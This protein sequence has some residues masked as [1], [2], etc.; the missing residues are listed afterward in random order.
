MSEIPELGPE[1]LAESRDQILQD[2]FAEARARLDSAKQA[3]SKSTV[4]A[5]LFALN[6]RGMVLGAL[7]KQGSFVVP[8]AP[9]QG[10]P[11]EVLMEDAL[12]RFGGE[13]EKLA[14]LEDRLET[15][16]GHNRIDTAYY[17][18]TCQEIIGE[19][20]NGLR[21]VAFYDPADAASLVLGD[22]PL[23]VRRRLIL[24]DLA[25][26]LDSV[27][28]QTKEAAEA[29]CPCG[30]SWVNCQGCY[31]G[32]GLKNVFKEADD[33]DGPSEKVLEKFKPNFTP[34]ELEDMNV[35]V[36]IHHGVS[37]GKR[38][39]SMHLWTT[40]DPK[41]ELKESFLDWFKQFVG[42]RKHQ[43]DAR[44]MR[45]WIGVHSLHGS[46][47]KKKPSPARAVAL[48]NWSID[49]VSLVPEDMK[50]TVSGMLLAARKALD[51]KLEK[52]ASAFLGKLKAICNGL[53][54]QGFGISVA[55]HP[56][57]GNVWVDLHDSAE[58]PKWFNAKINKL[59]GKKVEWTNEAAPK[60]QADGWSQVYASGDCRR[61]SKKAS[62]L[63]K[64]F[65]RRHQDPID[66]AFELAKPYKHYT[67][68]GSCGC[69]LAQC[70][71][72][73]KDH[74]NVHVFE[75]TI[76]RPC[77]DCA[78]PKKADLLPNVE[79]LQPQQA[80]VQQ[81][82]LDPATRMLLYHG[83][84]TG[85]SRSA[86]AAAE[87]AGK[88]YTAVTP[89]ALRPN[90]QKERE[91]WTDLKTPEKTYSYTAL[92]QGKVPDTDTLILDEA[93]R[94]RSPTA[95]QTQKAM[96]LASRAHHVYLLSGTPIVNHPH[97]LAPMLSI[98]TNNQMTPEQFD[99]QFLGEEKV[100]PGFFGWM[101]GIKP[102][103]EPSVKNEQTLRNLLEG[104][105]SYYA[106]AKP[107]VDRQDEKYEVSMGPEQ[108][109]LYHSFWNQLPFFMRWKLQRQFPLSHEEMTHLSS[110]LSG[111][112]QVGLST[113]PF[114]RGAKGP[115]AAFQAFKQSPKLHKAFGLMTDAL[116]HPDMKGVVYSNFIEA[117][118]IPYA[119]ALEKAGV[120]YGMFH[121]ALN[122]V[123][124]K[125]VVDAYN[126]GK[127]KVL[128]LGP[129]ASEG[130]SLKGT[131]LLQVLDPHW[132][133]ARTDQAIGRGI[134]FDSH[135]D[136]PIEERNIRVQRFSSRMP[137][138][139]FH[140][141][142]RWMTGQHGDEDAR[143]RAP[144]VD[145]YL[146]QR[147]EKNDELNRRFLKILQDVGSQKTSAEEGPKD[148]RVII[149]DYAGRAL[150]YHVGKGVFDYPS[151]PI[152]PS[153]TPED[154][155]VKA[156][157][158]Y[159]GYKIKPEDLRQVDVENGVM[160][161]TG[162]SKDVVPA[163]NRVRIKWADGSVR[164]TGAPPL[165]TE[166][167]PSIESER[168]KDDVPDHTGANTGVTPVAANPNVCPTC[169]RMHSKVAQ[170]EHEFP[171][172]SVACDLDGTLADIII[173]HDP[174]RIGDP[175]PG[176]REWLQL[177]RLAGA[178]II[179]HT[180]HPNEPLIRKWLRDNRMPFDYINRH[181]DQ[182][183][184]LQKPLAVAYLDDRGVDARDLRRGGLEVMRR[185][186]EH[187][188]R[189]EDHKRRAV[190]EGTHDARMEPQ[191]QATG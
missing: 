180:C 40:Q 125:H 60:S 52:K 26:D 51:K 139:M 185:I 22:D 77:G 159:T 37:P 173:P 112:R 17:L 144:G 167:E 117:G 10:P 44:Q 143:R 149:R 168:I 119:S 129:S 2:A 13:V 101:R 141:A 65:D 157:F 146:A 107:P 16:I 133:T 39:S 189:H 82:G 111:P 164:P 71:C 14:A 174:N 136:L 57:T 27:R 54:D 130:I 20:M 72:R 91:K 70:R 69:V 64:L 9:C 113:Y 92:A 120:P 45:R 1:D 124:R 150:H 104:H 18:G 25:A 6:D 110:F 116:K 127:I 183:A 4:R 97:D 56:E 49:P 34:D 23:S 118:L 93:Q 88:P 126:K 86:I 61:V 47:F 42:G 151:G 85:K 158:A 24:K 123:E 115:D 79:P 100:S 172:P 78:E 81:T 153:D 32:L 83:V 161:L 95:M 152:E 135:V 134:R 145:T 166:F 179:I 165:G 15:V 63:E 138:S 89:A 122:D 114:M 8:A 84:G 137:P 48:H 160:V 178:D 7:D 148:V 190:R 53:G 90:F 5:E 67:V 182:P 109:S 103:V 75:G 162:D 58:P 21:K 105:V 29:Y 31:S 80:A 128:L 106:P 140:R 87:T 188:Q 170:E 108:T 62:S 191:P 156:L 66:A 3:F 176:A 30:M 59:C 55:H 186:L 142:W 154:A 35:Y 38:F 184:W 12:G 76:P 163:H 155:G 28:P 74:E 33:K 68:K 43:D 98:L 73:D 121:G 96:D 102:G 169:G 131:R 46:E 132:N 19:P 171:R 99:R 36:R 147:A 11:D 50:E 187:K 41:G 177:F 181:P 175:R 94:L